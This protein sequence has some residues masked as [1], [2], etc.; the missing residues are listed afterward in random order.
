MVEKRIVEIVGKTNPDVESVT[1]NISL[2]ASENNFDRSLTS[3][4]G[5][6]TVSFVEYA[7][8]INPHTRIYLDSI[9]NGMK[10]FKGAEISVN[11][12][13]MGPP[14]NGKPINIEIVGDN[15]EDL[16]YTCADFKKAIENKNISGI[17]Q[18]KSDFDQTKPEVVIDIDRQR[19][20]IEGI[21][22]YAV[23]MEIK[24]AILGKEISKFRELEDQYPIQLRYTEDVRNSLDRLMNLKI[25]YRDMNSG[26]LRQIPLSSV[27]KISYVNSYGGIKRKNLKRVITLASN[28]LNGYNANE[29]NKQ[30]T[31]LAEQY[32]VREG[33]E[34]KLTGQMEDQKE[35][36]DFLGKA[37]MLALFLI[38]FILITQFNSLS[39]P[40]IIITEVIFSIIGVFIGFIIFGMDISVAMTG[41]G[42][43][44]LAGIVV[45]NGIL[46]VEFTDVLKERGLKTRDAIIQ[47][48]KTR[49][50]PVLLTATATILGLVPLAI[51]FNINFETMFTELNPHI[52]F[53]GDNMM[54]FGS[55]AWTIIFGLSFATVLT[56]VLIP[57]MYYIIYVMKFKTVRRKTRRKIRNGEY[58]KDQFISSLEDIEL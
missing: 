33:V 51:G 56:L 18:L 52:H 36:M 38:F 12:N 17:E 10:D 57:I 11:E 16:I 5:K 23:G 37:M 3:N 39:K 15:I 13:V 41:L 8:R 21:T 19:A 35:S 45:R 42:L 1:S 32:K 26:L 7:K 4:K 50:T 29:I 28:V 22:T 9:R 46:L 53:G 25:V 31:A 34:I 24:T 48:G 27:A 40:L 55:L 58:H 49:I 20:N 2:G 47:A 43:V 30:I 44:A 54:F 14:Q 6:V